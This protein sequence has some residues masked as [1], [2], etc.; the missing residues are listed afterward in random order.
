[1]IREMERKL[2]RKTILFAC[3]RMDCGLARHD[4]MA[5]E[6]LMCIEKEKNYEKVRTKTPELLFLM[7]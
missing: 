3:F 7:I 5:I 1:M 4:N 2:F 6:K